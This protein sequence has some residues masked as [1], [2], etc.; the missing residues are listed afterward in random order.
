VG[1]LSLG[2]VP[3]PGS[4]GLLLPGHLSGQ[5]LA[6][7]RL[8]F[9]VPS[10]SPVVAAVRVALPRGFRL[11]QVVGRSTLAQAQP[12]VRNPT[13]YNFQPPTATRPRYSSRNSNARGAPSAPGC[14][15]QQPSA[16]CLAGCFR[17]FHTPSSYRFA[18]SNEPHAT[19]VPLDS[20]V[21]RF[22]TPTRARMP[23]LSRVGAARIGH[24]KGDPGLARWRC[25]GAR[26][27]PPALHSVLQRLPRRGGRGAAPW[28]PSRL[29][30]PPPP[31]SEEPKHQL[32]NRSKFWNRH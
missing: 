8:S 14:R 18:S 4:G 19:N 31:N 13:T 25:P 7:V 11:A 17:S 15:R 24:P 22:A 23:A 32:A 20:T 26:P 28:P 2:A 27:P 29:R 9:P 6:G 12:A 21:P 1:R 10:S 5:H 30:A 16:P 3:V